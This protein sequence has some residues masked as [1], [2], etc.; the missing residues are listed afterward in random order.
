VAPLDNPRQTNVSEA[1]GSKR[2]GKPL[3]KW[4]GAG[5]SSYSWQEMFDMD[6]ENPG[7]FKPESGF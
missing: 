5:N 4:A 7:P 1:G 3:V 6:Q 2:A